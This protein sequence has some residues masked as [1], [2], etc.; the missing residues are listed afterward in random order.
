MQ[1]SVGKYCREQHINFNNMLQET[2]RPVAQ[3]YDQDVTNGQVSDED[4]ETKDQNDNDETRHTV[5]EYED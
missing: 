1:A 2:D 5:W 4:V 3:G